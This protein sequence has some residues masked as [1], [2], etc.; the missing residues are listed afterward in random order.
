MK[1][2][3]IIL[4]LTLCTTGCNQNIKINGTITEIKYNNHVI[5]V[6]DYNEIIDKIDNLNFYCGKDKNISGKNL[7]I[8]TTTSIINFTI[9]N[10]SYIAYQRD[11]NHCYTKNKK[12]TSDLSSV[13][14]KIINKYKEN[15]FFTIN[16]S[17]NYETNDDTIVK[18][19][20][21]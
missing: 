2:I 7:T 16:F 14:D 8:S 19:D 6:D 9:S 17:E 20:N 3:V 21:D 12:I 10:N 4:F 1:K 13:L 5:Y 11:N 15:N 18:I